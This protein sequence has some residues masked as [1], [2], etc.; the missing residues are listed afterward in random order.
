MSEPVRLKVLYIFP[1]GDKYEGECCQTSDGVAMRKGFGTQTSSSGTT[2]TG[3]W[4]DDKMN[5]S[6][7]LSHPSG[8][9]YKGQFRD[10]TYHGSGTYHFPDG[11]KYSGTFSNNRFLHRPSKYLRISKG[12][13]SH[14]QSS[15]ERAEIS[16]QSGS[17]VQNKRTLKNHKTR[18]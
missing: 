15:K 16:I 14:V 10:N 1:N 12:T 11:T 17:S 7:T 2:Y 18:G 9:V 6:G 8:A 4:N 5:G 3:E 13:S